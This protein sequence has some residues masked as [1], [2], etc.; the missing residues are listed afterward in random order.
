MDTISKSDLSDNRV[1]KLTQRIP[2]KIKLIDKPEIT[3]PG[4]LVEVNI[5]I[6]DK[7]LLQ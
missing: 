2:V 5:Q 4:M 7:A 6:Q 1:R 3:A